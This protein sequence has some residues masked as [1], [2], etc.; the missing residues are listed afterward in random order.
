MNPA[1]MVGMLGALAS[2]ESAVGNA[3]ARTG[4]TARKGKKSRLNMAKASRKNNRKKA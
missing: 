2:S 3:S 4:K 1:L